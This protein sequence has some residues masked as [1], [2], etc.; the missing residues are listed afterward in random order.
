MSA[1]Y[2]IL[3]VVLSFSVSKKTSQFRGSRAMVLLQVY[4]EGKMALSN[5]VML[6]C[7][8]CPL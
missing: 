5:K 3:Y 8:Y 2:F 1:V 6:Y 7:M 4:S